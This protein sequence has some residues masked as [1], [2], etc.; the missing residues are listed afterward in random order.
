MHMK[1]PR[2]PWQAGTVSPAQ[3]LVTQP[4]PDFWTQRTVDGDKRIADW[5]P[6]KAART[7]MEGHAGFYRIRLDSLRPG[8]Y[9]TGPLLWPG[10]VVATAEADDSHDDD[11][12]A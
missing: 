8:T 3:Q 11:N 9:A 1:A 10:Q 6:E 7:G 12:T 4:P 2:A 5:D